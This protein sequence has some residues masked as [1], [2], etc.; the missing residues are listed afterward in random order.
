MRVLPVVR[1]DIVI[2]E[3]MNTAGYSESFYVVKHNQGT[4]VGQGN[5]HQTASM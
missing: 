5:W 4:G 2:C 1:A 3:W